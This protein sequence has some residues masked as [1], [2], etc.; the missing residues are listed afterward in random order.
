MKYYESYFLFK[1]A[2]RKKLINKTT[3]LEDFVLWMREQGIKDIRSRYYSMKKFFEHLGK[4][5][6]LQLKLKRPTR[7]LPEELLTKDEIKAILQQTTNLRDRAFFATLYESGCRVGELMS[8]KVKHVQ[9]DQHGTVLIIDGKTGM[10]RVRLIE[11]TPYLASYLELHV[12]REESDAPLWY[13]LNKWQEA[14]CYASWRNILKRLAKE[15]GIQK[16]VHFHLFR[17]SRA[18]ELASHLTEQQMKAYLGWTAGSDMAGIYVHLSG[19]DVDDA[20]LKLHGK[21][22]EEKPQQKSS[23]CPRCIQIN[24]FSARYCGRCGGLLSCAPT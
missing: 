21:K 12:R 14:P 20:I 11:S 19:R 22:S 8:R 3:D 2:I 18:T 10:R 23:E 16:R 6:D 24:H 13:C 9:F 1:K 5:A 7:K 15:A 4:T 17:H